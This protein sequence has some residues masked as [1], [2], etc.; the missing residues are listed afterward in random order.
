MTFTDW[1]TSP[2]LDY[3]LDWTT[4]ES[5]N[6]YPPGPVMEALRQALVERCT[7]VHETV[8]AILQNAPENGQRIAADIPPWFSDF[9]DTVTAIIPKFVNLTD[10]EGDWGGQATCAPGWSEEDILTDI[11]DAARIP[12]WTGNMGTWAKQQYEILNRLV[13]RRTV[14]TWTVSPDHARGTGGWMVRN[15]DGTNWTDAWHLGNPFISIGS[16]AQNKGTSG[17][18]RSGN[19]IGWGG[20]FPHYDTPCWF[21]VIIFADVAEMAAYHVASGPAQI[22]VEA[23]A[24]WLTNGWDYGTY[25]GD[26]IGGVENMFSKASSTSGIT[27]DGNLFLDYGEVARIDSVPA[28]GTNW[29]W[30]R[31]GFSVVKLNVPGGFTFQ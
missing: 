12:F 2:E 13:W 5:M 31:G 1:E 10:N 9:D 26:E 14:L 20:L 18:R 22:S 3:L 25:N 6:G 23:D 29:W 4:A 27:A 30:A 7:I 17:T 11:D 19:L 21:P 8:P 24:Y 28:V 16:G 15:H